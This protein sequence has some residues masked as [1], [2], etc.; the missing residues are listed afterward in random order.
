MLSKLITIKNSNN[1]SFNFTIQVE[2]DLSSPVGI[3]ASVSLRIIDENDINI[4]NSLSSYINTNNK[5]KTFSSYSGE[6]SNISLLLYKK[7]Y[8]EKTTS[9]ILQYVPNNLNL[10]ND[11]FQC[12]EVINDIIYVSVISSF[13]TSQISNKVDFESS[14]NYTLEFDFERLFPLMVSNGHLSGSDFYLYVNSVLVNTNKVYINFI[15][16]ESESVD[17]DFSNNCNNV[18]YRLNNINKLSDIR[19]IIEYGNDFN[20]Q[21]TPVKNIEGVTLQETKDNEKVVIQIDNKS[22]LE[23]LFIN[24]HLPEY[25]QF[26]D[27]LTKETTTDRQ[28]LLIELKKFL[29]TKSTLI[30][31]SVKGTL[32]GIQNIL[33]VFCTMYGNYVAVVEPDPSGYNFIYRVT[34]NLP[35]YYWTTIIKK[36]VHPL[37]W[38]DAFIYIETNSKLPNTNITGFSNYKSILRAL[39]DGINDRPKSFLDVSHFLPYNTHSTFY[40][41]SSIGNFDTHYKFDFTPNIYNATLDYSNP[42]L[43]SELLHTDAVTA[44]KNFDSNKNKYIIEICYTKFGYAHEYDFNIT[45]NTTTTPLMFA[46]NNTDR[47]V[48]LEFDD[49]A[50]LTTMEVSVKLTNNYIVVPIIGTVQKTF[51]IANI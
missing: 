31:S 37:S 41:L 45:I 6:N 24:Q 14:I 18:L 26:F 50:N 19:Y 16:E 25:T 43:L 23:E 7:I 34:S 40:E 39:I 47:C 36:I 17:V 22:L 5:N 4:A 48:K 8:D 44:T 21:F 51:T 3:D 27:I 32:E 42:T 11:Y 49:V 9:Y 13:S 1:T 33:N 35:Q 10:N 46:D 2:T 28:D 20:Y 15:T 29:Y 38:K 30:H 12:N